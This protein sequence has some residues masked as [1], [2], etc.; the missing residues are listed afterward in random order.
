ML[1][2]LEWPPMNANE[3]G[4]KG[5]VQ[6][7]VYPRSS[8]ANIRPVSGL[9]QTTIGLRGGASFSLPAMPSGSL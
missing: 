7:C 2:R 3:R 9:W 8:A 4:F 5:L 6:I 1:K